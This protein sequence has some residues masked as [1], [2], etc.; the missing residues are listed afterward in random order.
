MTKVPEARELEGLPPAGPD[1]REV[2]QTVREVN[3]AVRV[4]PAG[5]PLPDQARIE[6]LNVS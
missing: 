2:N 4:S 5:I 6:R 3:Q 1:G